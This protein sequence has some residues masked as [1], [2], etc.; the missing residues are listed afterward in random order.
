MDQPNTDIQDQ[1]SALS[2]GDYDYTLPE[3]GDICEA[4]IL[5]V[6]KDEMIVDLGVKR[7]GIVPRDDLQSLDPGYRASL[8]VGDS[9]PV[10]VQD[11]R[12]GG[13]G[14]VVSLRDG[15]AQH[16][17]LRAA[18]L[19]GDGE[20]CEV[21]V[22][23]VN[24]G[25]VLVDFGRVRGFVP[26][27]HLSS[28]PPGLRGARLHEAKSKLIGRELVVTVLEV[29]QRRRRLILSER[30]ANQRRRQKLLE[31]LKEG[32]VRAGIVRNLVSYG[33]F[34]DLGGVDGLIHIS[35]L[36]WSHLDHPSDVLSVGDE[37]EVKVL[38][39]DQER[40]RIELSRKCLLPDPW[41]SVVGALEVDQVIEGRVTNVVDFGAFVEIGQGVEGLVHTSE[42][43]DGKATCAEL[44]VQ[45]PIMVR[46]LDIDRAR[47][48]LALSLRGVPDVVLPLE[49]EALNERAL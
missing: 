43:P 14:I 28:V 4:I 41:P 15:L 47:R 48:R 31:A 20:T 39:V 24:S 11:T 7:D 9:V 17:W 21:E 3:R 27:S 1:L 32:D 30:A 19:L 49:N 42:M 12:A 8:K 36:D 29:E 6:R 25:G 23:D 34:V 16:D 5:S 2:E 10:C 38:S 26:N 37:L 35:E 22:V 13:D 45:A 33:A 18:E 44:G 40:E 46:V